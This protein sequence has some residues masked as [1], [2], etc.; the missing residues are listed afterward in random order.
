[1]AVAPFLSLSVEVRSSRFHLLVNFL[2][3]RQIC[4]KL[5]F[6][7]EA[8]LVSTQIIVVSAL[9]LTFAPIFSP[10]LGLTATL[11]VVMATRVYA[12]YGRS[13]AILGLILG[14]VA[15][16]VGVTAVCAM[17]DNSLCCSHR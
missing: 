7:W 10:S 13:A 3:I 15:V 17:L 12:L 8:A 4:A 5:T 16:L 9:T 2:S 6:W 14:A 11:T 1:M